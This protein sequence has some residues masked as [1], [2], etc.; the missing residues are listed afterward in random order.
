MGGTDDIAS[1]YRMVPS[2][3]PQFS[4]VCLADPDSGVA[5]FFTMRGLNFG[6]AA[7]PTLFGR[8]PRIATQLLRRVLAVAV[9][10]FYDDFCVCTAIGTTL[11]V[12]TGTTHTHTSTVSRE[13]TTRRRARICNL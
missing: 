6:L 13:T 8:V 1:A 3:Y 7:A 4:V 5:C 9:T 10:S 12:M 11:A 2:A